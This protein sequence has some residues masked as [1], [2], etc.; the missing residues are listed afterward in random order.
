MVRNLWDQERRTLFKNLI[1]E[2]ESEGYNKE[3]AGRFAR[4]E[5]DEM[6]LEKEKGLPI[7]TTWVEKNG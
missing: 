2:Y 1:K 7:K 3:E 4:K 6:M 5:V